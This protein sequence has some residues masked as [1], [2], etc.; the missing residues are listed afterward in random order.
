IDI[1]TIYLPNKGDHEQAI[2]ELRPLLKIVTAE[3]EKAN[4]QYAIAENY[5]E[6][7]D[8]ANA[9]REFLILRYNQNAGVMWI[10]SAQMKVAEC[11]AAQNNIE[12]AIQELEAI[13]SRHGA[14]SM[15]GIG[16]EKRIQQ[17]KAQS[18][19]GFTR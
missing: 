15:Y 8:Y 4:I 5:F 17:I 3:D 7:G 12:Q 18:E 14:A 1:G 19:S 9:L 2:T 6:M 13:K 11:Y 10:A 16:A